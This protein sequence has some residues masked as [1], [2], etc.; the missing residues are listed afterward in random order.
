MELSNNPSRRIEQLFEMLEEQYSAVKAD[1]TRISYSLIARDLLRGMDSEFG[2]VILGLDEHD[3]AVLLKR[4]EQ[5]DEDESWS[6]LQ[7]DWGKR[8]NR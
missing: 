7:K 2:C 8:S 4:A 3:K 5:L 1:P 6:R